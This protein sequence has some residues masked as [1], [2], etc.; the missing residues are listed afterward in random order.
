MES[1]LYLNFDEN[2]SVSISEKREEKTFYDK[3]LDERKRQEK[4][5]G[6][7]IENELPKIKLQQL[8][9]NQ[10]PKENKTEKEEVRKEEKEP[11]KGYSYEEV[12]KTVKGT[13]TKNRPTRCIVA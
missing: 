4:I 3:V 12:L 9:F 8:N 7:V 5:E 13:C 6:D 1:K 10:Q 2:E 11:R